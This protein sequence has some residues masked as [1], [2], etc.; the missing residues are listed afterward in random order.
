MKKKKNAR[1]SSEAQKFLKEG[2]LG[3]DMKRGQFIIN[4]RLMTCRG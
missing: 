4:E 2:S 1:R 3:R